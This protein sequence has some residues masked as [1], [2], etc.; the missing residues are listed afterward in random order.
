MHLSLHMVWWTWNKLRAGGITLLG[1]RDGSS[2]LWCIRFSV[3][4]RHLLHRRIVQLQFLL[5]EKSLLTYIPISSMHLLLND[6]GICSIIHHYINILVPLGYLP[7]TWVLN[8]SRLLNIFLVAWQYKRAV[9]GLSGQPWDLSMKL[10]TLPLACLLDTYHTWA[11]VTLG[12]WSN[13]YSHLPSR[14]QVCLE[15]FNPQTYHSGFL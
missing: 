12:R 7:F 1:S 13:R 10:Y 5:T 3:L 14:Y 9:K 11:F 4:R 8:Y 6:N 2:T 15:I